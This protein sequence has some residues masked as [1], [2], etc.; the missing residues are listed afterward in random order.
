M[1]LPNTFHFPLHHVSSLQVLPVH[2]QI[3]L[4]GSIKRQILKVIFLQ[5]V[6]WR[7]PAD[8]DLNLSGILVGESFCM[9]LLKWN[10]GIQDKL[11]LVVDFDGSFLFKHFW[12]LVF[13]NTPQKT[14]MAMEKP[15]STIPSQTRL[16]LGIFSAG[17]SLSLE[18]FFGSPLGTLSLLW[19]HVVKIEDL[20]PCSTSVW[21]STKKKNEVG[22]LKLTTLNTGYLLGNL[23][24]FP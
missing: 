11:Y 21:K 5:R 9:E 7:S 6:I 13:R 10:I 14:K 20:I 17:F 8:Y 19:N 22:N 16:L 23:S 15:M 12:G 4:W 24:A 1:N 3:N 18:E 2:P